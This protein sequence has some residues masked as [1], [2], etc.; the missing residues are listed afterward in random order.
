M[1]TPF[2]MTAAFATLSLGICAS[3]S[4]QWS[5][6]WQPIEGFALRVN[7]ESIAKARDTRKGET[8]LV[9]TLW[10]GLDF[11]K[12]LEMPAFN[13]GTVRS[14]RSRVNIYCD[15]LTYADGGSHLFSGP[16]L[17][18]SRIGDEHFRKSGSIAPDTPYSVLANR[19]CNRWKVWQ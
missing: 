6:D 12:P 13:P 4:G 9:V 10:V 14:M 1:Q 7:V 19:Y 5:K 16:A 8:G 11:E 3:A 17:S 15:D 18:G 2:R